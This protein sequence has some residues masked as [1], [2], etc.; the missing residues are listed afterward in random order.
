MLTHEALNDSEKNFRFQICD[1]SPDKKR[2]QILNSYVLEQFSIK[3]TDSK[4]NR[5]HDST[6]FFHFSR[7]LIFSDRFPQVIHRFFK[8][9]PQAE[10]SFPQVF[11]EYQ[12]LCGFLGILENR[13]KNM[14]EMNFE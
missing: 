14:R 9:F 2:S 10:D 1:L 12:G 8:S 5:N 13:H 3:A 4:S 11:T 7:F 6:K